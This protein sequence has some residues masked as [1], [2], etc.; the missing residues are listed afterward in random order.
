MKKLVLHIGAEK[1][2]TTSIQRALSRSRKQLLDQGIQ[3]SGSL[4]HDNHKILAAYALPFGSKDVA[5]TSQGCADDREAY[6]EFRQKVEIGLRREV[7]LTDVEV[8]CISSEDLHRLLDERDFLVLFD[9]LNDLFDEIQVVLFVRRQDRMAISRYNTL[10][11]Y[12]YQGPFS[13]QDIGPKETQ[14]LYDFAEICQR[15]D[16]ASPKASITVVPYGDETVNS[17]RSSVDLFADVLGIEQLA[18]PPRKLNASMHS[19]DLRLVQVVRANADLGD[20]LDPV[21]FVKGLPQDGPALKLPASK[22][23][24]ISFMERFEASNRTVAEKYFEGAPLFSDNYDAFPDDYDP[25]NIERRVRRRLVKAI[26]SANARH[27]E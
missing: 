12:G 18:E 11:K 13:F 23:H 27:A 8:F 21:A 7:D 6:D 3:L 22:E 2:G 4:G 14:R 15:W 5:L 20:D 26:L 24:A 9:L 1:T 17:G 25:E 10:V 19:V 16:D